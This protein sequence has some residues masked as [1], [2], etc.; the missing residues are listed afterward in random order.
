[1]ERLIRKLELDKVLE[2]VAEF[3]H[4]M[5]GKDAVLKT[6][7]TTDFDQVEY[8]MGLTKEAVKYLDFYSISPSFN[9]DSVEEIAAKAKVLS[10]LSMKEL[11]CV[12]R[13]LRLSA[14]IYMDFNKIVDESIFLIPQLY[15]Q[16]YA[17]N[18][19]ADDIEF[20]IISEDQ[21]N[22]RASDELYK[23]RTA[24]RKVNDDIK[25]K[26][27]SYLRSQDTHKYLQDSIITMR[28]GRY[29]LPVKLEYKSSIS[30][31]VHD[32][33]SSGQTLFIE[34]MAIVELNNKLK[35]LY[36]EE[37]EEIER[38]LYNFTEQISGFAGRLSINEQIITE[39]DCI[40]SKAKY[41]CT[42]KSLCP[43]INTNGYTELNN[44][45]HPLIDKNKVVPVSVKF[46]GKFNVLLITGPNTGGKT[47]S[48]KT[49]GLFVLMVECGLFL[50]AS[51]SEIS[52][53][54]RV[55]IDIGD[56]QSI[57][58]NLST[59][60]SHISNICRICE[61][62][63]NKSLVLLDE[64]GAGTEPNEGSALALAITEYILKSGAKAIITTHYSRLYEYSLVTKGIENA[65]MEF[66]PTTFEPT[67]KLVMG[68][69]G[70]S[71]AIEI[72]K[73]LGLR[74]EIVES[75]RGKISKEKLSFNKAL[76][77]AEVI[78]Q[79]FERAK[80]E[81]DDIKTNLTIE[82]EKSKDQN[83]KL[84]DQRDQLLKNS[85]IEA[86][87]IINDAQLQ[88]KELVDQIRDMINN[89]QIEEKQ[90]FKARSLVKQIGEMK[91]EVEK[92]TQAVENE[93]IHGNQVKAE[94]L[95][96]GDN[97]FYKKLNAVAVIE[98]LGKSNKVN[99]RVGKMRTTV[100]LDELYEYYGGK[101][102][103]IAPK[104]TLKVGLKKEIVPYEINVLGLTVQQAIAEVEPF[105]DNAVM[106]NYESVRVIH[107]MGTGALR[108]GLHSYFKQN[109]NIK[110]FRLGVYGEGESGV[111]ILTLKD[112]EN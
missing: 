32:Q 59:F 13:F 9:F 91:L 95:N 44:A 53:Y 76:Q 77:E 35:T 68:V 81:I 12:K 62:V 41:A 21:M 73:R 5:T 36:V 100:N 16:I 37:K 26:M 93:V 47:V 90:L 71:N 69:P 22:D 17:N 66:N 33:S 55:F 78:R 24:I 89:S 54:D 60:S 92:E 1:M 65:S 99:I 51:D 102:Q 79:K 87:R 57:E 27:Q 94:S 103:D 19:V 72:A 7:P 84:S 83:K 88:A 15:T 42:T 2:R 61:G 98:G 49:V 40:F 104:A 109:R 20:C 45:R 67:F 48:L 30:G 82:L 97:V 86:K 101:K 43:Q 74:E 52:L 50:P 4:S 106:A 25:S 112:P 46:G 64:V 96:V 110:D 105:I 38:I 80:V 8:L 108:K 18:G 107:G 58:Q 111:T 14:C 6:V 11:L 75:A 10:T 85:K 39:L 70:S 23:I 34:P 29:V 3:A 31:I 63:T 28:E 56:E